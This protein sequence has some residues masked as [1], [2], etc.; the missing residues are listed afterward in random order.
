MI[1]LDVL[2][3]KKAGIM[4]K[5][6]DAVKNDK[7]D[8]FG[9]AF[10]EFAQFVQ[11][12]VMDEARGLV[13]SADA[14]ILASRG[15]RQLTS[16][17]T[18]FWQGAIE[19]MKSDPKQ[20][21][22]GTDYILPKTTVDTIFE[23]LKAAH[24][25]LDAIDFQNA[26]ALIELLSSTTTGAAVWGE[27]TAAITGE[28]S[29]TFAKGD[30]KQNKLTAFM[31][32][33]NAMLDLGPAW[34]DRYARE[35]LMEALAVQ[36]EA[37]DVDGD[38][39]DK[40]LGMTRA[41]S[42]ATDGVY[43]RKTAVVITSFDPVTYGT[44]L[45]TLSQ[46][47]NSKRRAV[48]EVI[49]VVNPADY[50]T[51]VM[52]A[53]TVRRPDGTY[54]NDVFPFPTKVIQS[55]A[56]PS[57]HAVM[58][59]AKR[60]YAPLGTGKGGNLEYDD[61]VK[62]LDDARAYRIKLYGDG[63]P[64][65]ANAFVYLDISGVQAYVQQVYVAG[66]EMDVIKISDARL[67]SLAIGNKTLSPTFNKSIFAYE[68]ATTDA[69]NTITAVAKDSEA[70]VLIKNGATTV[71]NGQAATWAA[72]ANTVTLDV[73]SGEETERYTVIVTKS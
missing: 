47:P 33:A 4:Q 56:M 35:V 20:T 72:G 22:T 13:Q 66:G 52:P 59:I 23:D 7:P 12:M 67:V 6:S 8:E 11:D 71:T 46:G 43:P 62:F 24:P 37:G 40:P 30:M 9:E 50:F 53:T 1:N 44:I 58:G 64:K 25:L 10:T 73:T 49:L 65:D 48:S 2:Q 19:A 34:M 57:G 16:E 14:N 32:V 39:K 5:M 68:C 41:L 42:G 51:K 70:T 36:L 27:I 45:N 31:V 54:A 21:L 63:R 60:Y 55:A 29:A 18:K 26:G 17:E 3:Q 15:I 61:S 28:M 69:T 38:G